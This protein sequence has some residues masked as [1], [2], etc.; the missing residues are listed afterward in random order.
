[1][2]GLKE[3]PAARTAATMPIDAV[4]AAT[5][6]EEEI[7]DVL[8]RVE[9]DDGREQVHHSPTSAWPVGG[10]LSAFNVRR[11]QGVDFLGAN[12]LYLAPGIIYTSA[13]TATSHLGKT[14]EVVTQACLK[15][16]GR[17]L[18]HTIMAALAGRHVSALVEHPALSDLRLV[19]TST[20]SDRYVTIKARGGAIQPNGNQTSTG[21]TSFSVLLPQLFMEPG[22]M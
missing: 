15:V 20:T 10:I 5:L 21:E 9:S 17:P 22:E 4:V 12:G 18:P 19:I 8:R 2:N 13:D 11:N 14:F 3:P 6:T 7:A 1:M 16:T